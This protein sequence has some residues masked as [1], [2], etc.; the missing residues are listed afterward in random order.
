MCFFISFE[1]GFKI[2]SQVATQGFEK[3]FKFRRDFSEGTYSE[4]TFP[5]GQ[6]KRGRRKE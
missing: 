4:G 3:G 2:K 5:K 1:K 6:K